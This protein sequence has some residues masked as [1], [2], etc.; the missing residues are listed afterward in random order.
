MDMLEL[1]LKNEIGKL[2]KNASEDELDN[3]TLNLIDFYKLVVKIMQ[4]K[5]TSENPENSLENAK[6]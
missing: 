6:K 1:Q 3:V 5:Q 2:Y 4:E